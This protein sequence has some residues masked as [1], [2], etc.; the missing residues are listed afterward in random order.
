MVAW[1]SEIQVLTLWWSQYDDWR[2]Y[3]HGIDL[4]NSL[5]IIMY[6][7]PVADRK[8]MF[9]VKNSHYLSTR[10]SYIKPFSINRVFISFLGRTMRP[11]WS[12]VVKP[13]TRLLVLPRS[14]YTL[15]WTSLL[16]PHE[17][18]EHDTVFIDFIIIIIV[19]IVII[20]VKVTII[21]NRYFKRHHCWSILSLWIMKARC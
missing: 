17:S 14:T 9:A 18:K 19:I 21:F 3:T 7:Y 2:W 13:N 1:H 11:Y 12:F 15:Y 5:Y 16:E 8:Q 10:L 20:A 4:Q 6:V